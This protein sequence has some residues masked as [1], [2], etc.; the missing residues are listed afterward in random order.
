MDSQPLIF[1]ASIGQGHQQA[2]L[3]LQKE[4]MR[5][6]SYKP[7]IIDIFKWIHP[8]LHFGIRSSY[9]WMLKKKPQMWGRFYSRLNRFNFF[10]RKAMKWL[11]SQLEQFISKREVP[12][13]ISTHPLAT[14]LLSI[15]KEEGRKR[16]PLFSVITDFRFHPAYISEQVDGYFTI[17]ETADLVLRQLGLNNQRV[18]QTGIPFPCSPSSYDQKTLR[19]QFEI[20]C[21]QPA[22]MLASG[23]DGLMDFLT[24]IDNLEE[25]PLE[26]T[27]LCMVGHNQT[28]MKKLQTKKS[29]HRI[30]IRPFTSLFLEYIQSCDLIV[31]KAGGLTVSE[32]LA[33]ETPIV[34]YEPI[35]GHEE[36][37]ALILEKWGAAL[38]AKDSSELIKD[39]Y[40]VIANQETRNE[41]LTRA[42][43]YRKPEAAKEITTHI[44]HLL[45]Q[46]PLESQHSYE[47][48]DVLPVAKS[49]EQG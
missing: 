24:I 13:V 9:L 35:V 11:A 41:L 44:L 48:Y 19:E 10:E 22:I 21:E 33:C 32:A 15:A 6:S 27:V 1:S 30:L 49:K 38:F 16:F 28:M 47:S 29:K 8:M 17:D 4:L 12:F 5:S 34:L 3:S 31:T 7:E 45:I 40:S 18:F 25:L 26:V 37:N 2:A 36:E 46:Y 14:W 43:K 39:I 42:R 20:N 23:S